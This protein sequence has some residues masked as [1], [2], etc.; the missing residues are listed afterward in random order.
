MVRVGCDIGGTFT[1]FVV[2]DE[3]S[4]EIFAEKALTT[5]ADPSI[6]LLE[7]L[8]ALDRAT[9]GY[10]ARTRRF[11]HATTLIANAVIE[12]KGAPTALLATPEADVERRENPLA[13]GPGDARD[14]RLQGR[15]T[16]V[17]VR[18]PW[19]RAALAR[20]G[21]SPPCSGL[22]QCQA[23]GCQIPR[24]PHASSRV[25][26]ESPRADGDTTPAAPKLS[27]RR[28]DQRPE[29]RP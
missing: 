3:A 25:A 4:G 7:G 12:R 23:S 28:E 16:R 11:A 2:L 10:T 24:Q 13:G 15:V 18:W 27:G 1:D 22:H 14:R 21:A 20:R 6:G 29:N 9:P 26:R 8:G 19:I 5:P 17:F